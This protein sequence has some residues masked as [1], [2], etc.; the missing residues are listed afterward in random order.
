MTDKENFMY[1]IMGKISG[2]DAP[3]VFKGALITKLILAEGG[4]TGLERQT[5][6]VDANWV[7]KPPSMDVLVETIN[8]SLG[9][10]KDQIY[11]VA[12][13][14]YGYKKSAGISIREKET[15]DEIISMDIDMRPIQGS[16]VYHYGE[17][18]VKGVFVNEILAD[19]ISAISK[20]MIFRR[21][22]D[23]VDVYALAHCVTVNTAGIYDMFKNNPDR[24][25]GAFDEFLHHRKDV[26]HAFEKLRD[27]DKKPP[28]DQVYSYVGSFI[29]PFANKDI[30]PRIWNSDKLSWDTCTE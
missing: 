27:I 19:K 21:A 15:D 11:A 23:I 6:D 7:E 2:T 25:M 16:R 14:E 5:K 24:E 17:I 28:F 30:A 8:N 3:V 4:Y 29:R 18:S 26:E 10:L 9:E 1:T 22:K 20:R 13:R 12:F